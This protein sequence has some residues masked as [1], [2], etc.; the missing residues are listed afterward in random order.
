[1]PPTTHSIAIET[2]IELQRV[3]D[4]LRRR[5]QTVPL[6]VERFPAEQVNF[7][8]LPPELLEVISGSPDYVEIEAGEDPTWIKVVTAEAVLEFV[9]YRATSNQAFYVLGPVSTFQ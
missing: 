4:A 3:L 2:R 9:V 8:P 7:R 5:E 6:L 1:M